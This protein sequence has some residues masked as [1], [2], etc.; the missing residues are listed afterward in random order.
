MCPI[1]HLPFP[2]LYG[3]KQAMLENNIAHFRSARGM[4][5]SALAEKIGTTLNMMGKLER[6]QRTLSLDWLEKI[7]SVLGVEA[8]MLIKPL[9]DAEL[10]ESVVTQQALEQMLAIAQEEISIGTP[11][12]EWPR[13]VA[14]SLHAQL[15]AIHRAGGIRLT[16]D[17]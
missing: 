9:T 14:S 12:G 13:I 11:L 8:Y 10:T 5:Q 1:G 16:S 2:A 4:S 3:H 7:A 15:A 17:Q 6:G